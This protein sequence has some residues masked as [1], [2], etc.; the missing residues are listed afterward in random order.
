LERR[1]SAV[2]AC[3]PFGLGPGDIDLVCASCEYL[4][5]GGLE[6]GSQLRGFVFRCQA[7]GTYNQTRT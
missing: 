4:L 1:D 2:E 7:C 6:R 5:V 3:G